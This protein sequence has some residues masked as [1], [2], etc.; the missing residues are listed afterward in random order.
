MDSKLSLLIME[1]KTPEIEK[2]IGKKMKKTSGKLIRLKLKEIKP[3][4]GNA[5]LHPESQVAKIR[6]SI[7]NFGYKDL[8]AVDEN[9]EVLEGHGRLRALYQIDTTGEK[10]INIWQISDFTESEKKAYRIAH[11]KIG[12]DTGFDVD[13]LKEEFYEL[14][15]TDNFEDT[16]FE[17]S[18]ISEMW[19]Q[20]K[21]IIEDKVDVNAYE[22]AKNKTTIKLGDIYLLGNHRLM[23][24]DST[25]VDQVNKL[26]DEK[27]AVLMVT[28]PP[29]GVNY[30]PKWRD[31]ADKKGVLGNRYPTRS[32]GKVKNDNQIDWS[33]AYRL[34]NGDV[35]YIYHAG[36]YASEV[37]N[38]IKILDFEL[39]NQI[40]WVKPHF[41]LSRGDYHWK[42]EPIWYAV[43]KGKSHNWQG[44]RKEDT[45]WQIA[46][47]NA[48]GSSK[49]K[50]D[51]STGHGTQKPVECMARPIRNNSSK[52]QIVY[53]PF[54][55][56]GT[57]LI[58]CEQLDRIC[59]M[60]ELDPVY[61][62]IIVDRY[63]KL[64]N[65]QAIKE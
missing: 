17:T 63:E 45:V 51:E 46:G 59:F 55:G 42:H 41:V 8:I 65:K 1:K 43:R 58:A 18:E 62:Q 52:D 6:D 44:S 12:A 15:G 48:M 32:L 39:I 2:E 28:D 3:Y 5:K 61:C 57:T 11:N 13:I 49:D 56:S 54:G 21:E 10:E 53:D 47:M 40:I 50:A 30:N 20:D 16:G 35:M 38:S 9:N 4:K 26:M 23:C 27:S 36:K 29:Y 24:G 33:K 25:E 31:E 37:A 14:E 22:R 19:D 7:I 60:M 64:T 34:F